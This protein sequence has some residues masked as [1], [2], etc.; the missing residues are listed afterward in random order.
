MNEPIIVDLTDPSAHI[1]TV[2][3]GPTIAG[4][5]RAVAECSRCGVLVGGVAS[6]V[7]EVAAQHA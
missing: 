4:V 7:I 5:A 3:P 6:L 1:V 2:T